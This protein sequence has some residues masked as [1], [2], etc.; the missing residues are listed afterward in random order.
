[1]GH[2]INSYVALII[3]AVVGAGAA[4]LIMHFANENAFAIM[5][6]VQASYFGA[7]PVAEIYSGII[8]SGLTV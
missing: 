3:I 8:Y 5:R 7:H 4:Q 1:M 2:Q 6:G